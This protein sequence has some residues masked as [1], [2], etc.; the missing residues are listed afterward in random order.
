MP[1]LGNYKT[2]NKTMVLCVSARDTSFIANKLTKKDDGVVDDDK[3]TRLG[4]KGELHHLRVLERRERR[5]I[6]FI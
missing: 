3:D 1:K 5:A 6:A 2:R 4:W